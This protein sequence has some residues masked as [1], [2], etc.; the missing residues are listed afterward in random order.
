MKAWGIRWE[1]VGNHAAR[2]DP[3]RVGQAATPTPR[4]ASSWIRLSVSRTV[5]PSRSRVCTT[6]TSG[7]GVL[8]QDPQPEAVG[9]GAGLLVQIDPL[10]RDPGSGQRVDLPVGSCLAV[11]TRA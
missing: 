1:W 11:E 5:R 9:G 6:I 8:E 7:P 2:V 3:D 10:G 4:S